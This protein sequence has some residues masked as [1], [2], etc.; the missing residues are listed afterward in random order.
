MSLIFMAFPRRYLRAFTL[1]E[2]LTTVLVVSALV[3]LA[4]PAFSKSLARSRQSAEINALFHAFY[5]ARKESIRRRARV[6]LC[7]TNDGRSCA[8]GRDWSNGWLLFENAPGTDP[9]VMAPGASPILAHGS[10]GRV[11]IAANRRG[12]TSRGVHKRATN[13]TLVFCDPEGRIAARAL[14]VS[15]TGRPRIADATRSGGHYDCAD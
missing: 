9:P 12:F 11:R 14:V 5:L 4:V 1:L 3:S 10:T 13:G 6:S 7:P 15:Y 2:L 8:P